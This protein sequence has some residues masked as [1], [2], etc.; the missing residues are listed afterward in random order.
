MRRLS[1]VFAGLLLAYSSSTFASQCSIP[2]DVYFDPASY[3]I[4]APHKERISKPIDKVKKN[5]TVLAVL[6]VGHS[7]SLEVPEEEQVRLSLDRASAVAE[8]VIRTYPELKDVV[9]VE[10]EG[11]KHPMSDKDTSQNRRVDIEVICV[12]KDFWSPKR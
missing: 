9:H 4:S 10:A 11:A 6:L 1:P 7:D 3:E 2:A 12:V 8:Y 5:N